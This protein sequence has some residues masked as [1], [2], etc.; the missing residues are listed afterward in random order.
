MKKISASKFTLIATLALTIGFIV[1]GLLIST[2]KQDGIKGHPNVEQTFEERKISM[3][4]WEIAM[5]RGEMSLKMFD[6]L[7]DENIMNENMP[8][9]YPQIGD[10]VYVYTIDNVVYCEYWQ[11]YDDEDNGYMFIIK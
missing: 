6:K 10:T 2:V 8:T 4:A 3:Q 11:G 9:I 7:Y 5:E 1:T